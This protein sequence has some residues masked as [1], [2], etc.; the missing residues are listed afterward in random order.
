MPESKV[1]QQAQEPLF[2]AFVGIDWAD[3]KHAWCLQVA[4]SRQRES[5]ELEHKVETVEAWVAQLGQRFGER[6]IAIAVEQLKGAL[7]YMLA[8]YECLHLYPVP[9]TM[10]ASMRKALHPSGAKDDPRDA[11]LL[12][13]FLF[14]ASRQAASFGT[15]YRSHPAGAKLGGRAA[16]VGE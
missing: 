14:A 5:G 15:G 3:Q 7:V 12:L 10:A 4:G 8:K 9:S 6:P 13:D 11:D 16:Q 2:A 1:R